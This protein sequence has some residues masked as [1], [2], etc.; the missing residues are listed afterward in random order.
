M[1]V[2]LAGDRSMRLGKI[3]KQ[4]KKKKCRTQQ[5]L[6]D[7][8]LVNGPLMALSKGSRGSKY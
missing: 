4:L 7:S 6:Q 8:T 1:C 5:L 3:C 2:F